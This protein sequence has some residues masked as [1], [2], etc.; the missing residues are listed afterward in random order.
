[1]PELKIPL[2]PLITEVLRHLVR[3]GEAAGT[4]VALIGALARD[5]Y[6]R[7]IHNLQVI[8]ATQDVDVVVAVKSWHMYEVLIDALE[9][10]NAF[11]RSASRRHRLDFHAGP[12]HLDV[13]P[14]GGVETDDHRLSWPPD[15]E[16]VMNSLGLLEALD[17]S[18]QVKIADDTIL[19]K[20]PS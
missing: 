1:M 20:M 4:R 13:V 2:D 3:A 8:R 19:S 11:T 7:H 5:V 18:V 16:V 15:H 12:H 17:A 10:T 9:S 6:L 14:C